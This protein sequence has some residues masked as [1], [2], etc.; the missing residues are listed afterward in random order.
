MFR[1]FFLVSMIALIFSIKINTSNLDEDYLQLLT[2][3]WLTLKSKASGNCLSETCNKICRVTHTFC[4]EQPKQ[5]WKLINNQD[6]SF[7]FRSEISEKVMDV[8]SGSKTAGT[9]LTVW[10]FNGDSNQKFFL[11]D[12]NDMTYKIVNVNS[13][14]CVEL[15][16]E[17]DGDLRIRQGECEEF[18]HTQDWKMIMIFEY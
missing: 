9:E 5:R 18:D 12:N 7:T 17:V 1:I 3:R 2:D 14:M 13:G 15:G 16:E 4:E 10:S 11:H 8:I 6:G